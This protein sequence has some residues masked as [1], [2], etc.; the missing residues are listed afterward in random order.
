MPQNLYVLIKM[1]LDL[2]V[3]GEISIAVQFQDDRNNDIIL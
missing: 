2:T 3:A 1:F